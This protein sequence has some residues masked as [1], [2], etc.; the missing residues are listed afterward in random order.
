MNIIPADCLIIDEMHLQFSKKKIELFENYKYVV[1][2]SA[3]P[4]APKGS[5]LGDFYTDIV[6]TV[7]MSELMDK[8]YLSPLKYYADPSIDL[9]SLK[10]AADGDY[11]DSQLGE[12]MDKPMLVGDILKN[13]I[14]IAKGKSTV[15][16]ASS[17]SHA[18]HLCDEFNS[19]GFVAE[20]VD[21]NTP[22]EDRQALFARVKSGKTQVIVNVGIVSVGIDIPNLEVVVLARPTRMISVYLQCVGRVTRLSEGKTHG[23][24][25]DHAGIIEKLGFATDIIEWTLDGKESVEDRKEKS[26]KEGKEPKDIICG[27]CG[28]VFRAA[29]RCPECGHEM[30]KKGEPLPF[31]EMDLSEIKDI[32]IKSKPADKQQF[33]AELLGYSRRQGK[34]DSFALAMFRNK[35]NEWP[36]KKNIPPCEPSI[37]TLGYIKHRQIAFARSRRVAA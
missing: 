25:I 11:M 36:Y 14:R 29:R 4:V 5:A 12:V 18:R 3:T 7:T 24:V 28:V 10:V 6:E 13:W 21:C 30:I 31:H 23:I 35:F 33:Y 17:Q 9:S 22:D 19:H 34:A 32:T 1:G 15:I 8:G 20:Y 2:F 27:G 37:E 26:Q 16:F